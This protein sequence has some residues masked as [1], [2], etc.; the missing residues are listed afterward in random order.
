MDIV[1]LIRR[2]HLGSVC[3]KNTS[4]KADILEVG[5]VS[6]VCRQW[7]GTVVIGSNRVQI[8]LARCAFGFKGLSIKS[9]I[10]ITWRMTRDKFSHCCRRQLR[11]V[12][13]YARLEHF[14]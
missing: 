13:M 9:T 11:F 5:V 7:D 8:K 14:C 3:D 1:E 6:P 10:H 12:P 2:K 4:C